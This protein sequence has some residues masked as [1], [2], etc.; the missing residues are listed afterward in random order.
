MITAITEEEFFQLFPGKY[1]VWE[2]LNTKPR[3]KHE[4]LTR[5]LPS[6]LWRMN[7]LYWI[8]DKYGDAIPFKMKRAQWIVYAASLMHARLI[9]LKSRQQGISTLW[10]ISFFDDTLTRFNFKSGLMAQER[11]SAETLL[12]RVK[13]LWDNLDAGVKQHLQV[14]ISKNNSSE[15]SFSNNSTL[16]VRTSFR[17]ATL[18]RLHISELGKIANKSPE[19][20]K[21]TKTGSLQAIKAGNTAVIESTAEGANMF[22]QMWDTAIAQ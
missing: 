11:E 13:F 8:V 21:E 6:K 9:I 19:K 5:Y 1:E 3:S 15:F 16:Y 4:L 7:N 18:Q 12:E 17:S 14:R 2:L 22:K 10:L 20:A